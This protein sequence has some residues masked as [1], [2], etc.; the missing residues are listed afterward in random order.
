MIDWLNGLV[1]GATEKLLVAGGAFGTAYSY[2]FTGHEE[3]IAWLFG[4]MVVDFA[5]GTVCACKKGEWCSE[6]CSKG[7]KKKI[8]ILVFC[9]MGKGLDVVTGFSFIMTAFISAFAFSE[10]G[11]CVETIIRMGYGSMIPEKI[12]GFL[13]E[14]KNKP[15]KP[16]KLP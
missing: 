15:I 10:T 4:F 14:M 7:L 6:E 13:S 12:R 16:E 9:C 1:P 3:A 5:L 2:L 11:S 8:L